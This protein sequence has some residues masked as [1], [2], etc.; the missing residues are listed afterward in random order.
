MSGRLVLCGMLLAGLCLAVLPGCSSKVSKS[1]Y[2]KINTGMTVAEVEGILGK[3]T[4]QAGGG[5]AIGNVAGSAKIINWKDGDK[6]I[7]VTFVNDKV[8]LKTESGL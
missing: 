5:G 6:T 1:N 8:T 4:E 3:G 7:T 2:D